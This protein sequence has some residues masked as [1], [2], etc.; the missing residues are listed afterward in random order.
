[1][2]NHKPI[3]EVDL[4]EMRERSEAATE[5][6]WFAVISRGGQYLDSAG[7]LISE[8]FTDSADLCFCSDARTDIPRLLDEIDRLRQ[9]LE[10]NWEHNWKC[11]HK[12]KKTGGC[13]CGL[14]ETLGG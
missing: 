6:P 7:G 8:D 10:E 14:K 3:P 13:I 11:K 5:G 12:S 2:P 9:E 1:M 4:R